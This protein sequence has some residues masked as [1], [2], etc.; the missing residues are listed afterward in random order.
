MSEWSNKY[1]T[2]Y[3]T[4]RGTEK[5]TITYLEARFWTTE[6]PKGKHFHSEAKRREDSTYEEGR[7]AVE[8]VWVTK[9]APSES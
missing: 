7:K 1:L 3:K 8:T 5:D 9:P 6:T 2:S 4:G